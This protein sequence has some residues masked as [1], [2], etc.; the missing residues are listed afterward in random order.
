M[1]RTRP[2]ASLAPVALL[3]IAGLVAA[4]GYGNDGDVVG[5]NAPQSAPPL[6]DTPTE[7]V[8]LNPDLPSQSEAEWGPIWDELP[9]TFPVPPGVKSAEADKGPVSAAYTVPLAS[10]TARQ[11]AEFYEATLNE[12]G[13]SASIDGP[14]EDGSIT[15]WATNGYG[16]DVL[17]TILPRSDESLITVLYGTGCAFE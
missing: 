6:T 17:V 11:I 2:T 5:S 13:Y 15:T 7:E 3:V 9:A 14:L 12:R 8:S 1:P 16:C 4:C 10:S